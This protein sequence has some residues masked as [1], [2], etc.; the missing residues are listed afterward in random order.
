M[1]QYSHDT[2]NKSKD[3]IEELKWEGKTLPVGG[4]HVAFLVMSSTEADDFSCS[5]NLS[6]DELSGSVN[7]SKKLFQQAAEHIKHEQYKYHVCVP[8]Q[9]NNIFMALLLKV[10]YMF[11]ICI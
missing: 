5:V 9:C 1:I 6:H 10:F 3:K 8:S 11:V 4:S 2:L 7:L